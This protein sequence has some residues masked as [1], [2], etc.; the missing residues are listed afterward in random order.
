MVPQ[1][2]RKKM[3]RVESGYIVRNRERRREGLSLRVR[4][5]KPL[6]KINAVAFADSTH[7]CAVGDSASKGFILRTSDGGMNWQTIQSN[8]QSALY[9]IA[10]TSREG[11]ITG[12]NGQLLRGDSRGEKWVYMDSG[13][14]VGSLNA[15]DFFPNGMIL[16]GGGS[17]VL[18][19]APG[20]GFQRKKLG[21]T[22]TW[23]ITDVQCIDDSVAYAT[24]GRYNIM[25]NIGAIQT[26]T[27]GGET[28]KEVE[29]QYCVFPPALHC[30]DRDQGWIAE[31]TIMYRNGSAVPDTVQVYGTGKINSFSNQV[32]GRMWAVGE[33]GQIY[34]L[35][36]NRLTVGNAQ[37]RKSI[38]KRGVRMHLL[39]NAVLLI[40]LDRPV[41]GV[42]SIRIFDVRGRSVLADR[43]P[44]QAADA[45]GIRYPLRGLPSGVYVCKIDMNHWSK[46]ATVTISN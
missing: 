11:W 5:A 6:F 36:D 17:S 13:A 15:I 25:T 7:G 16:L 10:F 19:Y 46:V 42:I 34:S 22:S 21:G 39:D 44:S 29:I 24:G 27:D 41:A 43:I 32:K 38:V 31:N 12:S 37:P 45:R 1:P 28:W 14:I 8:Y 35:R 4:F 3:N 18:K 20:S 40:D 30:I 9:D 26:T 2:K 23:N 33:H